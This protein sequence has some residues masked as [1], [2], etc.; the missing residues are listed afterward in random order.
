MNPQIA[1][2]LKDEPWVNDG[3]EETVRAL[4]EIVG[5]QAT[6]P[7]EPSRAEATLTIAK[8][9]QRAPWYQD[10]VDTS[11]KIVIAEV[12]KTAVEVQM[13]YRFASNGRPYHT[14]LQDYDWTTLLGRT[15]EESI[16]ATYKTASGREVAILG[17]GTGGYEE[18][19]QEAV[20]M[21][22]RSIA[23]IES[24]AGEIDSSSV[25]I[26]IEGDVRTVD[27]EVCGFA[28]EDL[29][30]TFIEG[31]CI[32]KGV[33]IHELVHLS[34]P[35]IFVAWFEEGTAYW[36]QDEVTGS[37]QRRS[38]GAMFAMDDPKNSEEYD[39]DSDAGYL[40]YSD[41]AK[42]LGTE[43]L[44]HH[45]KNVPEV[46]SGREIL[47]SLLTMTPAVKKGA[48]IDLIGQYCVDDA[49][50]PYVYCSPPTR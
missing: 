19:A 43:L 1:E 29:F 18:R 44:S 41:L 38:S 2:M 13:V 26:V 25:L 24:L 21:A 49:P 6:R 31:E 48:V 11:E 27:P 14:F 32:G 9:M 30:I 39:R 8:A 23:R 10:G 47:D 22:G 36:V 5:A 12:F 35:W 40:F 20:A 37:Q 15:F 16:F 46:T 28:V 4:R 17:V 3:S 42:L 34:T 7:D 45:I 33:V 50:R